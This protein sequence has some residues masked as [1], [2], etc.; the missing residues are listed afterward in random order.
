[1]SSKSNCSLTPVQ[2]IGDAAPTLFPNP[3]SDILNIESPNVVVS[4][5]DIHNA[6]GQ[7]VFT[8][9]KPQAAINIAQ[10]PK[11]LFLIKIFSDKATSTQ[12]IMI[13]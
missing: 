12:K 1:L 7:L 11:G 13:F 3:A 5:I 2:N 6:L 4:K 8:V 10:L 9:F